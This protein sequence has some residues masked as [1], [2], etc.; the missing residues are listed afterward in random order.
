MCKIRT[1]EG[2]LENRRC[3]SHISVRESCV[4]GVGEGGGRGH[5]K[6]SPV[7]DKNV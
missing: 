7:L 2:D 5:L 4:D 6:I 3:P 1:I